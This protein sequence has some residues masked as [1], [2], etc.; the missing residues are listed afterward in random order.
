MATKDGDG[1]DDDNGDDEDGNDDCQSDKD[2]DDEKCL[3]VPDKDILS[4]S[5]PIVEQLRLG[6]GESGS[7]SPATVVSEGF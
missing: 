2:D 7:C 1:G 4:A 3:L 5:R 6:K